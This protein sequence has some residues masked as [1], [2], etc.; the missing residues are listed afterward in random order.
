MFKYPMTTRDA[1][2][3]V[4]ARVPAADVTF[5]DPNIQQVYDDEK[6]GLCTIEAKRFATGMHNMDSVV[7]EL[8][9]EYYDPEL[10]FIRALSF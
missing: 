9:I 3:S 2:R 8:H 6:K 1:L 5:T 4:M 7:H 10:E